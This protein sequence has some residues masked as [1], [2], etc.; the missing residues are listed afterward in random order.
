MVTHISVKGYKSLR[1][2]RTALGPLAVIVGPNNVGKS[3]TFDLLRLL[4]SFASGPLDKAFEQHRGDPVE[5]LPDPE[6]PRLEI[7]VRLDLSGASDPAGRPAGLKWPHL[8]YRLCIEWDFEKALFLVRDEG[9][10]S[11]RFTGRKYDF[12]HR[13]EEP[14]RLQASREGGGGHPRYFGLGGTR[15]VLSQVDDGE[16]YP[17]IY[18]AQQYFRSW[19]FY[20]FDPDALREPSPQLNILEL[21]PD[22]R[23]LSGVLDTLGRTGEHRERFRAIERELVAAIP[24]LKELRIVDTGDR[25]RLLQL[26]Q[27]DGGEYTGRVVSDGVLRFL[28]L[29]ALAY[30]PRPP[31]L[32]CFEE[33]ENGVHPARIGFVVEH[34]RGIA[35]QRDSTP[36]CQVI[37]NSHSPHLVDCLSPSELV[38]A[39][40]DEAGG[41]CLRRLEE[42]LLSGKPQVKRWLETGEY[43]LG[44]V[45]YG[46]HLDDR[47]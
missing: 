24:E 17:T 46:G 47:A 18:A 9:L 23:G 1:D 19:R 2:V 12:I 16:L 10:R 43:T 26:V 5:C 13:A 31:G 44:E 6:L 27:A 38:L 30:T 7:A 25:R 40:V 3:N 20:H 15:T 39:T 29:L 21:G 11:T 45:W 42:G 4:S 14:E 36:Q 34:L 28:A 32:V 41:T 33:P 37:V 35:R 8:E 22:G